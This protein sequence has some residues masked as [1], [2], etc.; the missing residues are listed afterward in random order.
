[1]FQLNAHYLAL[2]HA[3]LK[4][5]KVEQIIEGINNLACYWIVKDNCIHTFP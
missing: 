3:L 1:M 2:L 4:G 5:E